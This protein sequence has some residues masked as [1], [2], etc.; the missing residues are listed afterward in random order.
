[1]PILVGRSFQ[2]KQESTKTFIQTK[3]SQK[4]LSKSLE[5]RFAAAPAVFFASGLRER[6]SPTPPLT[7]SSKAPVK[8]TLCRGRAP[9]LNRGYTTA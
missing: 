1:M 3:I 8:T 9:K 6:D 2:H 4:I 7:R 5:S